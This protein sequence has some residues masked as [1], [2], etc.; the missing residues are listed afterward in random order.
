MIMPNTTTPFSPA[1]DSPFRSVSGAPFVGTKGPFNTTSL[2]FSVTNSPFS[3]PGGARQPQTNDDFSFKELLEL[4][5]HSILIIRA[6]WFW[7]LAGAVVIGGLVG[8]Q[9]GRA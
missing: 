2:P 6:K 1:T 4:L 8:Y 5:E 9:I 7:G 3:G